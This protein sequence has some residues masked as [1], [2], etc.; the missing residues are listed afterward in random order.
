MRLGWWVRAVA[1]GRSNRTAGFPSTR[2]VLVLAALTLT[3]CVRD[4]ARGAWPGVIDTLPNGAMHVQNPRKGI[5]SPLQQWQLVEDLRIGTASGAE[6]EFFG[7][8]YD[9]DV[10]AAGRIYVLDGQ[11]QSVRVFDH[12]G[13]YVRT[14]GRKGAGPGEFRNAIGMAW[15]GLSRLWVADVA[16]GRY[17]LFDT[18]GGYVTAYHRPIGMSLT[19][20][21]WPGRFDIAGRLYDVT[22]SRANPLDA[23]LLRFDSTRGSYDTLALPTFATVSRS[24]G[25]PGGSHRS[26]GLSSPRF[27][28]SLDGRGDVWFALA[29]EYRIFVQT[30]EGDTIRVIERPYDRRRLTEREKLVMTERLGS[31]R[32]RQG[33]D[34]GSLP[35]MKAALTGIEVDDAGYL[36]VRRTEL[37]ENGADTFDLFDPAGRYLGVVD[38]KLKVTWPMVIRGDALYAVSLDQDEVPRVVRA[39]IVRAN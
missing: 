5:W 15:D 23:L 2:A 1:T 19:M 13:R 11:A 33:S 37:W 4:H 12:E 34:P 30:A 36:W 29:S 17:S 22:G 38:N 9:L 10:D 39:R 25:S 27:L 20:I 21:P 3:G 16:T 35:A 14:I 28:W 32:R 6:S 24:S 26:L 7:V 8:V 31:D 18:A